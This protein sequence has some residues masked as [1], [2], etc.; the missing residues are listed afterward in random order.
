[1]ISGLT[2]FVLALNVRCAPGVVIDVVDL[3]AQHRGLE[4]DAVLALDLAEA[5][6]GER[7]ARVLGARCTW[8]AIRVDELVDRPPRVGDL[9]GDR[10]LD[11]AAGRLAPGALDGVA[12][13]AALH[14]LGDHAVDVGADLRLRGGELPGL[15]VVADDHRVVERGEQLLADLGLACSAFIPPTSTLPTFTPSAILPSALL[16]RTTTA[17]PRPTIDEQ[18]R[19]GGRSEVGGASRPK[20]RIVK[21]DAANER[22]ATATSHQRAVVGACGLVAFGLAAHARAAAQEILDLA[23]VAVLARPVAQQR[24]DA[25]VLA[26]LLDGLAGREAQAVAV[27]FRRR[28]SSPWPKRRW[29]TISGQMCT[30]R[31]R[32][33]GSA[34]SVPHGGR[35]GSSGL[36]SSPAI[37]ESARTP[38]AATL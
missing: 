5:R 13:L 29:L 38:S 15:A 28:L 21:P 25:L 27:A 4:G 7:D 12:A 16:S 10:G 3:P 36:P 32:A 11:L 34:S 23:L 17:T 35:T 1:M 30:P 26:E 31:R 37:S 22:H 14:G 24:V 8:A 20:Y 6:R 2:S 33:M 19:G 18:H 9:G